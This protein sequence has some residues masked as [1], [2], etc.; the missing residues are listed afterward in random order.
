[1]EGPL[2]SLDPIL[3]EGQLRVGRR[4]GRSDL[5][6]DAKHQIILPASHP[7]V[8]MLIEYT[9]KKEGHVGVDHTLNLVWQKYWILHGRE[10]VKKV[11]KDLDV[12][13][14]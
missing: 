7:A 1:M 13:A 10:Q 9:H 2:R 8:N 11:I 5:N 12:M 14:L 4:I 3:Y 6:F